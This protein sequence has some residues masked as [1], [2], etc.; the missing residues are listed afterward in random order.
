MW[1]NVYVFLEQW[2][3]NKRSFSPESFLGCSVIP[4][5]P[6]PQP[7]YVWI[8]HP[9]WVTSS[10]EQ[11][12]LL[13]SVLISS[14]LAYTLTEVTQFHSFSVLWNET[15]IRPPAS[16]APL[17]SPTT[18]LLRNPSQYIFALSPT[19]HSWPH[20]SVSAL[21][22]SYCA[23]SHAVRGQGG[24]VWH[25]F[26]VWGPHV[27]EMAQGELKSPGL[28]WG[29]ASMAPKSIGIGGLSTIRA[30]SFSGQQKNLNSYEVF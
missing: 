13:G 23:V 14:V 18:C 25:W 21:R 27:E 11:F 22:C 9:F 2:H 12:G 19:C 29:T 28:T 6:V 10:T 15:H 1:L 30:A 17:F 7:L 8:A 20:F 26:E 3:A 24:T 5:G 4:E 16:E